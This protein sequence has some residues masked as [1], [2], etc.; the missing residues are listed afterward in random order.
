MLQETVEPDM[1]GRDFGLLGI[2][3]ALAMPTGMAVLGPLADVVS[4]ESLLI[5]SGV[6][7]ALTGLALAGGVPRSAEAVVEVEPE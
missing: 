5:R 7:T 2:V 3:T 1:Q 6:V 4:V